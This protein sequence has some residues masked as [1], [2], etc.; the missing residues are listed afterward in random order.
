MIAD[1]DI[2]QSVLR[3]QETEAQPTVPRLSTHL[4]ATAD[5][6]LNRELLALLTAE[7]P[8]VKRLAGK[9]VALLATNGVEE[10]ELTVPMR[11]L[12]DRGATVHLVSPKIDPSPNPFGG[13]MPDAVR[14]HVLTI[15]YMENAGWVTIDRYLGEAKS[16]DY[17][18][19]V[20]PGGAWNPDSLR[21]NGDA[22]AFVAEALNAGKPIFAICHG[23]LVLVSA[24]VLRGRKVTGF[25]SI[26]IDLGNAGA[27]VVDEPCVV[28][29]N[30]ITG[31]F[32]F[33]LPR[34]LPALEQQ[35][36]RNDDARDKAQSLEAAA[37]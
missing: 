22:Q 2:T 25:W 8:E 5:G 27:T 33:D 31:R 10:L 15:R 1:Q 16:S 20:V 3:L 37:G 24:R 12:K 35:L 19:V 11:W 4:M 14:T 30:L 17:D 23:P 7:P 32:P 18:A 21:A 26:Q 36:L 6:E 13:Q 34:C 28:D 9:R 29:G